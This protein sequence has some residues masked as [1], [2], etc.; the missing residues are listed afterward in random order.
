[1][2][3]DSNVCPGLWCCRS[4][5]TGVLVPTNQTCRY[6]GRLGSMGRVTIMSMLPSRDGRM[7]VTKS[8]FRHR[9]TRL[10]LL[11]ATLAL[12]S[13]TASAAHGRRKLA[14]DL[15]KFPMNSDGTVDVIIQF[16]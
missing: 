12:V 15:S 7:R 5:G 11:A 8:N 4:I 16:N 14:P 2:I 9:F 13:T 10:F 6:H 1:K 3:E